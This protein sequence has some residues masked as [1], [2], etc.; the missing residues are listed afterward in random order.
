MESPGHQSDGAG[1]MSE[2]SRTLRHNDHCQCEVI[3]E[4][5][6]RCFS[7]ITQEDL[8]CDYCRAGHDAE[9]PI[10]IEDGFARHGRL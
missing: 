2:S 3:E 7:P 9:T 5:L 8:L 10:W 4:E 1:L 6:L